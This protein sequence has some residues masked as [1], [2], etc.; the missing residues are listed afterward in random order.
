M[1]N[2]SITNLP[3][4]FLFLN[5]R[6]EQSPSGKF[7]IFHIDHK[8]ILVRFLFPCGLQ[9]YGFKKSE[10]LV[11]FFFI[12]CRKAQ[13]SKIGYLSAKIPK[14]KNMGIQK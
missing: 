9:L 13:K 12:E 8:N 14:K 3:E 10:E 2:E 7:W 1:N 5:I 11:S 4:L 6:P